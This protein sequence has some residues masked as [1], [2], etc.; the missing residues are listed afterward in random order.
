VPNPARTGD[1]DRSG[2]LRVASEGLASLDAA[3]D[4]RVV[5]RAIWIGLW[6][7][8]SFSVLDAYMCFVAYPGAPFTVFVAYRVAIELL[9]LAVY[10]ASHTET[11]DVRRLFGWLSI[12]FSAAAFTIALMAVHLGGIRSPYMHGI[13]IAALV[14][15][16]LI[17]THWR[18]GLPTFV[19]IGLSFPLVMGVGTVI[20]P[21][22]RA[23]WMTSDALIVFVSN[24]VF[25]LSSSIL[26][27]I[28]SHLVWNA[29]QQARKVGSY[30]LEE[31]LGQGGMGEVWRARHHLL[32]RRAAIKLIRPES[33]GGDAQT[34]RL[35]LARFER[36]A[37]S[38]A[39]LRSPHTI[40]V[41]DFGISDTGS[42]FYVME[43]LVGRDMQ[44]LVRDFG[45]QP[46]AR[47]L[48][49][50]EQVCESL[51]EAHAAG[52]VHRD[53][54]PSN[55]YLCRY[56]LQYDFVKVLDF[57]L[58]RDRRPDAVKTTLQTSRHIAGTPAYMAPEVIMGA[59]DV[60][61]RADI[62]ALACVAYFLLTG[63][64]VFEAETPM[65]TLLRHVQ[66]P[67][68]PPSQR[69]EGQVPPAFEELIMQC[70]EKD[71]NRRPPDAQ[72]VLRIV[73]TC[74]VGTDWDGDLAR[75]WWETHLPEFCADEGGRP[76]HSSS[77]VQEGEEFA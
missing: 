56:G 49:L 27:A 26:S 59:A 25:V 44:T 46:P 2:T 11:V 36:E 8:P 50:L 5:A 3:A 13:S 39:S 15:A 31:R 40:D 37:Q 45:Q 34:R 14:W 6:T 71:P 17:P 60:D 21:V 38:T 73:R 55:I 54:K 47:V 66:D 70:L 7:W 42:F 67:P 61:A 57:G 23:T 62:Y 24:Y 72:A 52:L 58:A 19:Q 74:R 22:A 32:A 4:R 53:I 48:Y 33:L 1:P 63:A 76:L 20:S 9:F 41:Y 35:A 12:S 75:R 30:E 51:A 65:K 18:R 43:L 28:L 29:Q 68:V 77:H 69:A 16:A 10:R 64:L